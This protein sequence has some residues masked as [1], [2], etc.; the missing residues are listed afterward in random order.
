MLGLEKPRHPEKIKPPNRV[1]QK[2]SNSEGPSLSKRNQLRPRNLLHNFLRVAPDVFQFAL[3]HFS[4]LLRLLIEHHPKHEQDKPNSP[5]AEECA[6]PAPAQTDPRHNDGRQHGPYIGSR[7]KNAGGQCSF[8]FREPLRNCLDTGRK[9]CG[10]A[11]AQDTTRDP[12]TPQ[13]IAKSR[14][15]GSQAPENHG[16][17]VTKARAKTV[18]DPADHQHAQRI[19][20]L[21]NHREIAVVNLTPTQF[22][23]Q[24]GLEHPQDIAVHVVL[25]GANQK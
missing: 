12:E 20:G 13:G 7:V 1:S 19:A 10:F 21:E 3:G 24:R 17:G 4:M 14:S 15:H 11:K 2:F 5:N 23:L 8:F 22:M 16:Q 6:T 9:H 18:H 25:G